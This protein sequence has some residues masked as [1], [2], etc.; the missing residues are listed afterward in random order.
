MHKAGILLGTC[1]KIAKMREDDAPER[2]RQGG[3][4]RGERE[5]KMEGIRKGQ[6]HREA[7]G[8]VFAIFPLAEDVRRLSSVR[9]F[10]LVTERQNAVIML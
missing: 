5:K 9:C 7:F 6:D 1:R 10:P 4:K 2:H 8:F 3:R